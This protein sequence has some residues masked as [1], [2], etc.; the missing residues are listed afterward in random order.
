[1]SDEIADE[2]PMQ[3]G[4]NVGDKDGDGLEDFED[5][6]KL[7]RP[8]KS[9]GEGQSKKVRLKEKST[10]AEGQS[11]RSKEHESRGEQSAMNVHE[12]ELNG[13][14]K[15]GGGRSE[16]KKPID[17]PSRGSQAQ[18]GKF[19]ASSRHAAA[20]AANTHKII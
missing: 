11:E 19:H 14:R 9:N 7:E 10:K 8:V 3:T 18:M 16:G 13:K 1:M 5:L 2:E 4:N 15:P 12:E 6:L 17:V 20:A